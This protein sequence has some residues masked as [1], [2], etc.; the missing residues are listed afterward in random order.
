MCSICAFIR[1]IMSEENTNASE[2]VEAEGE[3]NTVEETE[4]N[5]ENAHEEDTG[6]N[7]EEEASGENE[8]TQEHIPEFENFI[9]TGLNEAVACS[10]EELCKSGNS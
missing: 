2:V 1:R 4:I 3:E 9:N 8:I 7:A 6:V 10:I 5:N